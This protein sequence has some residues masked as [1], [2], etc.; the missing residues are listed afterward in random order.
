PRSCRPAPRAAN[1]GMGGAERLPVDVRD[2]PRQPLVSECAGT[3][4][5]GA[6]PVWVISPR[7][8]SRR[9]SRSS[10]VPPQTLFTGMANAA[11]SSRSRVHSRADFAALRL[12]GRDSNPDYLIQ[13]TSWPRVTGGQEAPYRMAGRFSAL[14][15]EHGSP[16][17]GVVS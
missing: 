8:E 9:S 3:A 15:I 10:A 6:W 4:D 7:W 11:T 14:R 1:L 2:P 5:G 17:L 13:R 12:R 16:Q